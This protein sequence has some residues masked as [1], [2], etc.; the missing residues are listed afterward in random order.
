MNKSFRNLLVATCVA[1]MAAC[2]GGDSVTATPESASTEPAIAVVTP[3]PAVFAASPAPRIVSWT[4]DTARSSGTLIGPNGGSISIT[5]ADG[6]RYTL[7][8]PPNALLDDTYITMQ[9]VTSMDGSP[10]GHSYAV[11][12]LPDGLQLRDF[13]TLSIVPAMPIPVGRQVMFAARGNGELS[14]ALGGQNPKTIDLKLLHFTVPGVADGDVDSVVAQRRSVP[15]SLEDRLTQ[16]VAAMLRRERLAMDA[17][18]APDENLGEK[19]RTFVEAFRDGVVAP[20]V[21]GAAASCDAGWEAYRAVVTLHRQAY[22]FGISDEKTNALLDD[23]EVTGATG[24]QFR[25]LCQQEAYARC[26]VGHDLN[27]TRDLLNLDRERELKGAPFGDGERL[28]EQ[29][30]R[31]D[32]RMKS[33]LKVLGIPGSTSV[34]STVTT[35]IPVR[36]AMDATGVVKYTG[37]APLLNAALSVESTDCGSVGNVHRGDGSASV[38]DFKIIRAPVDDKIYDYAVTLQPGGTGEAWTRSGC[39]L[40]AAAYGPSSI[41]TNAFLGAHAPTTGNKLTIGGFATQ[42][43]VTLAQKSFQRTVGN[44]TEDTSLTIV[45]TPGP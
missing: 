41:W 26:A 10:F 13:A 43:G 39:G 36:G 14:L 29:C 9:P 20:K 23:M 18:Q 28:I 8:V 16:E 4:A 25:Q 12:L 44:V 22:F 34:E 31:F 21:R 7:D 19:F 24:S 37:T 6:S 11:E 3:T 2:G 40:G 32:V 30:L 42:T 45:H 35:A 5:A 15:T 17:G 33:T 1:S 38:T 27:A